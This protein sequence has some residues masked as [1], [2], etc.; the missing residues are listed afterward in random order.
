MIGDLVVFFIVFLKV[1]LGDILNKCS[2]SVLDFF[3]RKV[4]LVVE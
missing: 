2:I 3:L 4:K 1:N